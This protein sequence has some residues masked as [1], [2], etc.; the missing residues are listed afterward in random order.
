[1]GLCSILRVCLVV[2]FVALHFTTDSPKRVSQADEGRRCS[3]IFMCNA[4]NG[5]PR[6]FQTF[7]RTPLE[8]VTEDTYLRFEYT[9]YSLLQRSGYW[10]ACLRY[11][12]ELTASSARNR[13]QSEVLHRYQSA[14]YIS[15]M[16]AT[17]DHS[18]EKGLKGFCLGRICLV[19]TVSFSH[20]VTH[21]RLLLVQYC[22]LVESSRFQCLHVAL[23]QHHIP[24]QRRHE[25][26]CKQEAAGGNTC[27]KVVSSL[28]SREKHV[29][30]IPVYIALPFTRHP[31]LSVSVSRAFV[32]FETILRNRTIPVWEHGAD[33]RI[34]KSTDVTEMP[35]DKDFPYPCSCPL[36]VPSKV[37][38]HQCH[39]QN[40]T[41]ST[42]TP[43]LNTKL[44][45][46]TITFLSVCLRILVL[47]DEDERKDGNTAIV[48]RL[49]T[50]SFFLKWH[51][52]RQQHQCSAFTKRCPRT[53]GNDE[54]HFDSPFK[55]NSLLGTLKD[56][57]FRPW[58]WKTHQRGTKHCA[59]PPG[60]SGCYSSDSRLCSSCRAHIHNFRKWGPQAVQV[61]PVTR[62]LPDA[63]RN[64]DI[65][66]AHVGYRLATLSALPPSVPVSRI[67]LAD[68]GFYF[69]GQND[70]VTCY[71]CNLRHS[72]WTREDNP[73]EIHRQL[74]PQC[75]H[76]IQRD[77]EQSAFASLG[78]GVVGGSGSP[79]SRPHR[80]SSLQNGASVAVNNHAE[81]GDGSHETPR[82]LSSAPREPASS[83]QGV[84]AGT[85]TSDSAG[86]ASEDRHRG[87][88]PAALTSTSNRT[89][90]NSSTSAAVRPARNDTSGH[91]PSA[92]STSGA[93]ANGS[94]ATASAGGSRPP[95]TVN[96]SS[97]ASDSSG[98]AGRGGSNSNSAEPRHL[99]PRAGLDL[100]GAV[101]PMY[102]DMASR[103]RTF[104]HWDDSQGP[105]LD[106]VILCGMF[107]AGE[108]ACPRASFIQCNCETVGF[109]VVFVVFF[110]FFGFC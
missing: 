87:I 97:E 6:S 24:S 17:S 78:G 80:G 76:V 86:R 9:E 8:R 83:H 41:S 65:D 3:C 58:L 82:Q 50:K 54:M 99:F 43:C 79:G 85:V 7:T 95:A 32:G 57:I 19:F 44:Y 100:G 37:S 5:N 53:K 40:Y 59:S 12:D 103:R 13:Q 39:G 1:M 84:S 46:L 45:I 34:N 63:T 23:V 89:G 92:S 88:S 22:W 96:S 109:G 2:F 25:T 75:E 31:N 102:Q 94:G 36:F 49:F 69:R 16:F 11:F 107:Y 10:A 26:V 15:A 42:A 90:T 105:P 62:F 51:W 98:R 20:S 47:R 70:E 73:M 108:W 27:G 38:D 81:G 14:S 29:T 91:S 106:H 68:A 64:P 110:F 48:L 77:R 71:S 67:K 33:K 52:T 35:D 56:Y 28:T 72:G 55:Q 21:E 66:L 93:R 18:G 104:T 30:D 4:L 60:T 74:S 61:A 101:Y